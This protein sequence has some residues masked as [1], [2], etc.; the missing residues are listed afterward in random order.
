MSVKKNISFI[1]LSQ[2]INTAIGL[3]SSVIV[4]RIL[5]V[6]GKGDMALF[7][8]SIAFAVLFFG[9][10]INSTIPFFI[11][12]GKAKAE[13]LLTT[14]IIFSLL[15]TGLV[16]GTLYILENSGKLHWALPG[17]A[18]SGYYKIIFTLIYFNTLISGVLSTFLSAYKRFKEISIYGVAFQVIPTGIYLLYYFN[19]IQYDHSKPFVEVLLI[20]VI[21]S[22]LS[23]ITITLLFLKNLP[24]RP[25]KKTIPFALVKQFV[26]FSSLAYVG[27]IA[28][29]FNYKLDFW[30]V[31]EYCGRAQLG[32][33]SLAAQLSQLLWMLPSAISTVLYAYASSCTEKEAV[34]YTIRLKQIAF[35]G[36]LLLGICGLSLAYYFIPVLY[37]KDFSYAFYLMQLFIIGVV[38]FSIPTVVSSLF[39]ARG[40]FKI[41]FYISL[42]VFF[43]ST[44]MYFTLIPRYGI[45]GGAIAS[46][47]AYLIA[48]IVCEIL[49]CRQYKVSYLNLFKLD[50][51][52]FS[53][54]GI[55]KIINRS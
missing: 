37:G 21:V 53:L 22:V 2:I 17:N 12:S 39:A 51:E 6:G 31:D 7:G 19:I 38:P 42:G 29:F 52:I 26:L 18:Q 13:E 54:N 27:N 44:A 35:Y 49:F 3:V 41:S 14:I 32:V 40:N 50:K 46:S 23:I 5:G 4:T 15:S 8:N 34:I 36:T 43:I 9:F 1:F 25:G 48:S 24:V 28:Q 47:I 10:S 45:L 16:F 20:T 30:V 55:K 11:N 33:Y